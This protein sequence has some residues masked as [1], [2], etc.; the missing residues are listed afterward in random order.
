MNNQLFFFFYNFSHKS[1][2]LDKLIV[3]F[4]HTFPYI[5]I[6]LAGVFLLFHH[7]VLFSKKPFQALAEKWKEIIL[8]FFTGGFAWV[9][10]RVL[11]FFIQLPRPSS[12]LSDITTLFPA[13]GYAFP[14]GHATFYMGLAVAI[15]LNHK[16]AGLAFIFF[17]I[18]IGLARI[19]GGV[20]FPGDILGGFI[21]GTFVAHFVRFLYKKFI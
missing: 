20:H 9:I 7:E 3:F 8:V 5:V 14:S 19:A 17:A 11:K 12:A 1:E 21:L 4:A 10:A 15:Y 2:F 6:L 16:K 18:L 13:D